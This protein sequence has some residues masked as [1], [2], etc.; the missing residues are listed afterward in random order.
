MIVSFRHKGLEAF[1]L[2]GSKAGIQAVHAKRLQELL[3]AL[4]VAGGRRI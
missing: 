3:T 2:T 4:N 1:F